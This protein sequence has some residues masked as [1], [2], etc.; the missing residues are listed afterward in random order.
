[1][2]WSRFSGI[3]YDIEHGR[4]FRKYFILFARINW[5]GLNGLDAA[6]AAAETPNRLM[7]FKGLLNL[8]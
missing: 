1:M 4:H 5:K 7:K 8:R 6:V 2:D 3:L